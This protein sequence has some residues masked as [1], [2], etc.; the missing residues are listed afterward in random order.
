MRVPTI[1]LPCTYALR[2][3]C[4]LCP[5]LR[6]PLPTVRLPVTFALPTIRLPVTFAPPLAAPTCAYPTNPESFLL[7]HLHAIYY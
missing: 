5:C 6:V 2:L 1:R 4:L 3:L 7:V